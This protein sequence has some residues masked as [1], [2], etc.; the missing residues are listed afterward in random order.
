MLDDANYIAQFD[1]S[2]ALGIIGGQPDQLRQQYEFDVPEVEDLQHI[3]L[4]GMGGSALAAEFLRSWLSD[5]LPY[6]VEIVRDY[7]L[8][9]YVNDRT[10]VV[11]SSYSGNTEETL[12]TFEQ[13]KERGAAIAVLTS[14][15]KLAEHGD[16]FTFLKTPGGLQPRLAVLYSVKA[17]A[18]LLEEMKLVDGLTEELETAAEWLLEEISTFAANVSEKDNIAKQLA[19]QLVGMVPVVYGGPTLGMVAMKWKIDFN[20][21]SK[22]VAFWNQLPEW[23]HNEFLGWLHG[24][25]HGLE[26]IEL[27]SSLDNERIGKRFAVSN[28]LLSGRMPAPIIVEAHGETKLQQMLWTL[29]LGDFVSAYL[30]FLNQVDPTPVDL[31][32]KLKHELG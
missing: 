4:A 10:L 19:K 5:R 22:N 8:P 15:G 27:Q 2:N 16:E 13:A 32:E 3:V 11:V 26:V 25:D 21:N 18:T 17:L 24:G 9:A 6:P 12:S 31:I 14:G 1:R 28:K 29:L 7:A 20:E 30:A 23:N